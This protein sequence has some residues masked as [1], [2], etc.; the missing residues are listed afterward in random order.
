MFQKALKKY[1][2]TN[3]KKIQTNP[4]QS[5]PIQSIRNSMYLFI[6]LRKCLF[7]L[8]KNTLLAHYLHVI[9]IE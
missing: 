8:L 4:N 6:L 5:K 9:W 7:S 3:S 1:L 2:T